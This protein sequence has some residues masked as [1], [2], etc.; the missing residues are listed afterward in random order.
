MDEKQV[1]EQQLKF[2][3][4]NGR[5]VISIGVDLLAF[6]IQNG[7]DWCEDGKVI[8]NEKFALALGEMMTSDQ[9][10]NGAIIHRAL[11]EAAF[12]LID[13]GASHDEGLSFDD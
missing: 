11:D 9:G 10:D 4:I 12:E 7:P 6:A 3:L 13:S 2:E 8:D 5:F 1:R